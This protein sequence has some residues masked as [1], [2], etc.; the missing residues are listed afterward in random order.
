MGSNQKSAR[1]ALMRQ[2]F[3]Q[4]K[5]FTDKNQNKRIKKL[6]N[7]M[8]AGVKTRDIKANDASI[9]NSAYQNYPMFNLAKGT[10]ISTRKGSRVHL[11]S[12]TL[13]LS[14]TRGDTSNIVRVLV[15]KTPSSTFAGL[16]DVLEY[17]NYSTDSDLVFSSPY[18]VKATN[19]EQTYEVLADKVIQLL[20]DRSTICRKIKLK[21]PKKGINCDFVGDGAIAPNNY[22]VSILLISD[23]TAS[24]HPKANY[25][26]RWKYLD[27]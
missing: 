13:Y 12:G 9:Q 27:L 4:G 16:S 23:S 7:F 3:K 22:N 6:E 24:P 1:D 14:L 2:V 21:M 17:H 10:T 15:V 8:N 25:V 5:S 11:K 19:S 18:Q 20:N 26:L